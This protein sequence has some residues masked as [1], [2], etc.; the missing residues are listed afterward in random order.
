MFFTVNFHLY[1]KTYHTE[2]PILPAQMSSFSNI[3]QSNFKDYPE[4]PEEF[5]E[6]KL[7]FLSPH[8]QSFK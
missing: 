6:Y 7:E 1:L 3:F 2:I 8:E 5:T 4:T